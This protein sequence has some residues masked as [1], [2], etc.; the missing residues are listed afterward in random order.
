MSLSRNRFAWLLSEAFK[1]TMILSS[2]RDRVSDS[3]RLVDVGYREAESTPVKD[4]ERWIRGPAA[5]R[6]H[7]ACG[8]AHDNYDEGVRPAL[9]GEERAERVRIDRGSRV[10]ATAATG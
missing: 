2:E 10:A 3:P 1:L 7:E 8:V 6:A 5:E 9:Y 4:P